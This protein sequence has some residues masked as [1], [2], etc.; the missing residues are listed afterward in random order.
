MKKVFCARCKY[1]Y[2]GRIDVCEH[3][4]NRIKEHNYAYEWTK[5]LV[6]EKANKHNNCKLYDGNISWFAKLWR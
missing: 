1:F 5:E 6:C 3:P 4:Q 2:Y